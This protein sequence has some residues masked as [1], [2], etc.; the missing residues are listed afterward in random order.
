MARATGV[1]MIVALS[2]CLFGVPAAFGAD[3]GL[4]PGRGDVPGYRAG[5]G[6]ARV[7]RAAVGD[8][9]PR[10]LRHAR[11][12][13]AGFRT[14]GRRL[15]FGVFVFSGSG[16]ARRA[17]SHLRAGRRRVGAGLGGFELVRSTRRTTDVAV[18]FRVGSAVGAVRLR[19]RGRLAG[20]SALAVTYARSLA[21]RL[22][23]VLALTA[24][25]RTLDGIA[26]DGSISPQLALKAFTVAYGPLPGVK[27]PSGPGGAPFSATLAM[28][29]VARVWDQLSPAQQAAVDRYL[30]APHDAA[31][32]Q[33][34]HTVDQVLTP[35]PAYQALADKYNAIYRTKLPGAPPVPIRV[36]TASQDI[37]VVIKGKKTKAGADATSLNASGQWGVGAPAYCRV[38]VTPA[39]Q[40]GS[41]QYKE[42]LLAHETFHCF[43]FALMANWRQRTDWII[44]GMAD[45]AADTVDSASSDLIGSYKN[46]LGTPTTALFA[47]SYDAVG[48]WGH[49]DEVGGRGSLWGKIP[50]VLAAPDD[51]ASYALAGGTASAF[52]DTWASAIWRFPDA[53]AAWNQTDPYS[54]P[55]SEYGGVAPRF[56]EKDA[57]LSAGPYTMA[58]YVVGSNPDQPLV[59]VLGSQGTLRAAV[60]KQDFGPVNSEWFCAGKCECPPGEQSSVPSHKSF[61]KHFELALTGGASAGAGS[62]SYHSLDEFCKAT[63][64]QGLQILGNGLSVHATFRSGTCSVTKGQFHATARD[65]AW[66]IDV[67]IRKFGGYR[68]VYPLVH[69]GDPNFV[70]DGPGGPYSNAFAAPNHAPEFGQIQFYPNGKKMSFGF[71]YA[72]NASDTNAVLPLGV[73]ACKRPKH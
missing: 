40:A 71:E 48:F 57:P 19:S 53:G 32:A 25:Q 29:L 28:Q 60:P 26:P 54:V 7:A 42:Y 39:G 56:V 27:R 66:S 62:V 1:C 58:E 61:D 47:R 70:I 22:Q 43:E 65:G 59:E 5:A 72:W 4:V 13:G 37:T 67:R 35:S 2:A 24:W 69:G 52:V 14:G 10:A 55:Q 6:G 33:V 36:F 68:K 73:M 20:G 63:G 21:A 50:G 11:A 44:E 38:R 9:L 30:G 12:D 51:A 17:L 23:R 8:R 3:D 16:G 64:A 49:A 31:S 34:A 15:T 41:S 18:A 46:Y 45:W